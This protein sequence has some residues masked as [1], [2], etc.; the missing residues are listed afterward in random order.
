[1]AISCL[2]VAGR[3]AAMHS[4]IAGLIAQGLRH[5]AVK[6]LPSVHLPYENVRICDT[7]KNLGMLMGKSLKIFNWGGVVVEINRQVTGYNSLQPI[8]PVRFRSEIEHYA[9]LKRWKVIDGTRES[10]PVRCS[11]DI[12]EA[13]LMARDFS[14]QLPAIKTI[15][16]CPVLVS[17]PNGRLVQVCGYDH[18]SGILADGVAVP[19][20]ALDQARELLTGLLDDFKFASEGDKSRALAS[21]LTPAFVLSGLFKTRTPVDLSEAN[22]SQA[23]KGY[24]MKLTAAIYH[25]TV[26][27]VVQNSGGGVG[28]LEESFCNA[29]IQGRNFICLDNIR[30]KI[31]SPKI[32]SFLTE[33]CF[34][35]RVPY[36]VDAS[37]DPRRFIIMFTS[38][39]AELT[40]DFSNRSYLVRILKQ[41]DGYPFKKYPEGDLLAHVRANWSTYLGAVFTIV[42]EW[43][44]RGRPSTDESRHDFREWAGILDWIV[45]N[46]LGC[47]PLLDG[48][49]EVQARAVNPGLN[50]L[51]DVVLQLKQA[52]K[53]GQWLRTHELL[54]LI[55]DN[56]IE[57]PGIQPGQDI[58]GDEVRKSA[59]QAMGHKL[60]TC[61]KDKDELTIDDVVIRRQTAQDTTYRKNTF[62]YRIDHQGK[63]EKVRLMRLIAPDEFLGIPPSGADSQLV[64]NEH[65]YTSTNAQTAPD[66]PDISVK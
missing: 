63:A 9:D 57:I 64:C 15:A 52:G 61:F 22:E 11:K 19:L 40:P 39:K 38:N 44:K 45:Q 36:Q 48:H 53:Y 47:A 43:H 17:R 7:A 50:W 60:K 42:M 27:S 13:L 41:P 32:E 59:C 51:R 21:M 2:L 18:Q 12:A 46:V 58:S 24:R 35:A 30:G 4:A 25:S 31:N 54:T 8:E 26:A 65:S 34:S 16:C 66:S 20:C 55:A 10:M 23:G 1:M 56:G 28:S 14:S 33:D 49:R 62:E 37:I 6:K 29:L 3:G 5:K